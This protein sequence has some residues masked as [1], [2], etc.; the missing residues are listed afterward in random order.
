MSALEEAIE[1]P[2]T[3]RSF[4]ARSPLHGLDR[5]TVGFAD[6]LAQSVAAVAPAAAS[7]MA[8]LL[9]ADLAGGATVLV[10]ALAMII[11]FLV[12]RTINQFTRRFAASGSLYTYAARGLGA[13]G[14]LAT[15]AAIL[16]GYAFISIFALLGGAHYA[17]MLVTRLWPQLAATPIALGAL[18]VE[19]AV[20]AI[21]LVR[22]IRLSSRV[23]LVVELISVA[24]ILSL[25]IVLLV[26]IGPLQPAAIF[27]ADGISVAGVA[28]GAVL[29]IT[30]FVGFESSATLGVEAR[31]PLKNIPRA[32]VWSVGV[33]GVFY[34]IAAYTQIA[35][36]A[37]IGGTA[38]VALLDDLASRFGLSAWAAVADVGIATSGLACAI[39]STTALTR[40][41]FA[42]ARDGVLPA[43]LGRTHGRH[44]TPIGAVVVAVPPIVLAPLVIVAAGVS[45][46]DAMKAVLLISAAGYIVA[47]VLVCIAAPLFLRRIGEVTVGSI[48]AAVSAAAALAACLTVYLV[49]EAAAG[50][51]GVWFALGF[52]LIAAALIRWRRR[53]PLGEVGRYDEPV[54]AHVL[55]GVARTG[56]GSAHGG[57][58]GDADG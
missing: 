57:E 19:A 55:G 35:G 53:A 18:V 44:R 40:I 13:A 28:G 43:R 54:A 14:G 45:P 42:L 41:V 36:A 24:L 38:S 3:V 29:A 39:A 11:T 26:H 22:G 46:W 31:S 58:P 33:A 37:A 17:T 34:L 47:Y 12:A 21:V 10:M 7:A 15:G 6:I 51:P 8:V 50:N 16:V 30:A 2:Q 48:I 1:R 23:A 5:H 52:A 9:V 4:A 27:S 20:L 49:A 25:M 56:G 32:I